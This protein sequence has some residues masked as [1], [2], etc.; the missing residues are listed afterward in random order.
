MDDTNF[1]KTLKVIQRKESMYAIN[2]KYSMQILKVGMYL[3]LL[4][5]S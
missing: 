1:S 2:I 5:F 3:R 4:K